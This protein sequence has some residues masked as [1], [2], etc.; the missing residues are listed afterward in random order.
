[1][2]GKKNDRSSYCWKAIGIFGDSSC[3]RLV[4]LVHCRNCFEYN[5]AGRGLLDREIPDDFLEEWTRNLTCLKQAEAAETFSV[6]VFR[7]GNEWLALKTVLLQ[8]ATNMRSVHRIPFKSNNVFKGIVNVN[9][10]LLLCVSV[11]DLLESFSEEATEKTG[12]TIYRRMLVVDKDRERYAFPVDEVLGIYRISSEELKEPPV[13]MSRSPNNLVE[14]IFNI[15]EMKIG[16]LG[17]NML[18]P[19]F[20][21]SLKS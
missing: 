12:S 18:I 10:E 17:E 21:R 4:D 6:M 9:G 5:N 16:L 14:G 13:T 3:P 7:I 11:A 1:M 20:K 8:E 15:N 19:A 2:T